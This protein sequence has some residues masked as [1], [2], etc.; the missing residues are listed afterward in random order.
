MS[1]SLKIFVNGNWIKVSGLYRAPR[2]DINP[3]IKK[4]EKLLD[5]SCKCIILGDI[6]INISAHN[7]NTFQF[8]SMLENYGATI[9][10][11]KV[12]RPS[13][14]TIIDHI[15]T[16]GIVFSSIDTVETDLS[17][18]CMI[19]A[20]IND[21]ET[22]EKRQTIVRTRMNYEKLLEVTDFTQYSEIDDPDLLLDYITT[23]IKVAV[24]LSSSEKIYSIKSHEKIAE[25]CTQEILDKMT[26]RHNLNKK[27]RA[28]KS[29]GYPVNKL[30]D[31]LHRID[32]N[33][34]KLSHDT[35][36][37]HLSNI[38]TKGNFARKWTEINNLL[39][40]ERRRNPI[41]ICDKDEK[42]EDDFRAASIINDH[43]V[44]I[45]TALPN[46]SSFLNTYNQYNT[47][48]INHNSMFLSP[49]EKC[50]VTKLLA[51]IEIN[52]ST[53]HDGIT[54]KVL[55]CL[56]PLIAEPLTDLINKIITHGKYPIELKKANVTLVPKPGFNGNINDLRPISVLPELNKIIEKSLLSPLKEFLHD[57]GYI[58][59]QQYGFR[60]DSGTDLAIIELFHN[61]SMALDSNKIIGMVF[62]DISKAFD[63]LCHEVLFDKLENY[64]VR[65]L[66]QQLINSYFEGRTQAVKYNGTLSNYQAVTRGIGQGTPSGPFYFIIKLD[67][68]KNLP[69][70]GKSSRFA[71]DVCCYFIGNSSDICVL[72]ESIKY[73]VELIEDY[74]RING[75]SLNRKKTKLMII[76][77]KNTQL[78]DN[79]ILNFSLCNNIE[80]VFSHVYLG[81]PIHHRL[82]I[83][84]RI[85]QL[86]KKINPVIG[87]LSKLKWSLP[88]NVLLQI[89]FAHVHSHIS[90]LPQIL[91]NANEQE[92]NSLQTLQNRSLKHVFML[93]VRFSSLE[94]YR[95]V[96][97]T[98]LPVRGIVRYSSSTFIHKV[99]TGVIRTE[100]KLNKSY[101]N[102]RNDGEIVISRNNNSLLMR[103]D[104]T[105]LGAKQYNELPLE[106][107]TSTSM[108][109]FK[110]KL[111]SHL[112]SMPQNFL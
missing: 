29:G 5:V 57:S 37:N 65:G 48:K 59:D 22:Y 42:I 90:D 4:I 74:H 106:I 51:E 30:Q 12:T 79:A 105:C 87:I 89:Y 44:K 53:G 52:K 100:L 24:A 72:L 104:I 28:K 98:I 26:H 111:K 18:H 82:S 64:G 11:N 16:K 101:K 110:T 103:N 23:Q 63:T 1:V 80:R 61:L 39:G 31:K 58:D 33:I 34:K 21:C 8:L 96:A 73:D 54:G 78:D 19:F 27:I 9:A 75:M 47:I 17:D 60:Q 85:T 14:G 56:G 92:L 43:L 10:N 35:Y 109:S 3:L 40:R 50:Q 88:N 2:Y 91:S 83:N 102:L 107:R 94:L 68:F 81:V 41:I 95:D 15:I 13:S 84:P 45:S 7:S 70:R 69:L 46:A 55:K 38:F 36:V 97:K 77:K 112:L 25:W 32:E 67:D 66:A 71:D 6:N 62:F 99:M 93:P 86:I 76:A 20:T 49:I 108:G